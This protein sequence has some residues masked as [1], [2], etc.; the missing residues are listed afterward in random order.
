MTCHQE[1]RV[2][3]LVV[4]AGAAGLAA[5]LELTRRGLTPLVLERRSGASR[6][7]RATAL[8]AATMRLITRWGAEPEVRRLGFRSEHA[9]SIRSCLTG[10]EIQRLPF[11]DHVWT[12]AQDHLETILAERAIQDGTQLRY[13]SQLTG[14]EPADGAVR[15]TVAAQGNGSRVIRAQYVVGADGAHSSV[16]QASGI[17]ASRARSYGHWISILF[18]SPLRDYTGDEP[19]M[20][21]GI[22]DP[23]TSGVFVPADATDRWIRGLPWHPELGER[24]EDY[25]QARCQDL[26][27]C[28]AGVPGLPVQV[29][30][31][32]A[33]E[34]T[35][36][37]AD[38][39]RAGRVV[40]AGDAAHVFTPST[41][42]GLNLAI[43]DGAALA[44]YL[45][46]AIS[47]D[48]QPEMLDLY[49]HARK[50][51]AEKL[52]EPDLAPAR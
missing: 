22:G 35:A 10:P 27:R 7:P 48:D 34:M 17:A 51:L 31:I 32:R 30:D 26:V 33:F 49:E 19:C 2:Q 43:H 39:Y 37:I 5:A 13:G 24:L 40:L 42:M 47:P 52:L 46:E 8:T 23:S 11:P 14:L 20:V 15:A 4:G 16:R 29:L 44:Q 21:Y 3:V 45:A 9:M 50:P 36:S 41:G 38:R 28:G 18:R 6:H 12:C 1:E 25:S